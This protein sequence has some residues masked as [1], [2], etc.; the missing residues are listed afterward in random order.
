MRLAYTFCITVLLVTGMVLAPAPAHAWGEVFFKWLWG[1][2]KITPILEQGLRQNSSPRGDHPRAS[3]IPDELLVKLH[4]PPKNYRSPGFPLLVRPPGTSLTDELN[5][6]LR[7]PP[8][9]T[10]QLESPLLVRPPVAS[11]SDDWTIKT[12]ARAV[13]K[14][15]EWKSATDTA[16]ATATTKMPLPNLGV[17]IPT[18]RNETALKGGCTLTGGFTV[19]RP[20]Q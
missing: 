14:L 5:A 4:E 9:S 12:R 10:S 6:K 18:T 11:T 17:S 20:G 15:Q 8:T 19:C 2:G 16:P 13:Q 1:A 3:S 7:E